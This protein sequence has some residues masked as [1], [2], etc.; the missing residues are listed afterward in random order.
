[1]KKGESINA[2]QEEVLKNKD[3]ILKS[4][5]EYQDLKQKLEQV[6]LKHQAP[7][8][9]T[10]KPQKV[11]QKA[12][13]DLG[14]QEEKSDQSI[15]DLLS[16]IQVSQFFDKSEEGLQARANFWNEQQERKKSGNFSSTLSSD[17]DIDALNFVTSVL[18]KRQPNIKS[19][20]VNANKL[21][22][23]S[24]DNVLEGVSYRQLR[25]R[26]KE[27]MESK[28]YSQAHLEG[29]FDGLANLSVSSP[30]Q[31]MPAEN[32]AVP[33][34]NGVAT[35]SSSEGQSQHSIE[36]TGSKSQDNAGKKRINE[37]QAN[38]NVNRGNYNRGDS[39]NQK[40]GGKSNPRTGGE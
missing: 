28:T 1:L 33:H 18:I 37:K 29:S 34:T 15:A 35:N 17:Q 14:K 24:S 26:A 10:S 2:E 30:N 23:F 36:T 22:S 12:Q 9:T 5:K 16:F 4:L 3:F 21:L 38:K 39:V 6:Q 27:L 31:G 8:E 11:K 19:S 25:E 40:K 20:V 7:S 32:A 13:L